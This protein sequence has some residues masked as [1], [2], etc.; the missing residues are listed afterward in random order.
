MKIAIHE[1]PAHRFGLDW[2]S[3]ALISA[4]NS[5]LDSDTI[6]IFRTRLIPQPGGKVAPLV[7]FGTAFMATAEITLCGGQSFAS[8]ATRSSPRSAKLVLNA[9]WFGFRAQNSLGRDG[10]R[11][12]FCAASF[13]I[14][15]RVFNLT[16]PLRGESAG[17]RPRASKG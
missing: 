11:I 4:Q 14:S 10:F 17:Y 2:R 12:A 3:N 5:E 1:H 13:W 15:A 16:G 8:R 9:G 6:S 7:F